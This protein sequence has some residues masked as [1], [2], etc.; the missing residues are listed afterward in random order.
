MQ[1]RYDGDCAFY[2]F[3]CLGES[4]HCINIQYQ[5]QAG[6]E[7]IMDEK[8]KEALDAFYES[9]TDEQKEKVKACKNMDEVM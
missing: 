2:V 1:K 8:M 3:C 4:V 5:F 6:K 9:L 7:L